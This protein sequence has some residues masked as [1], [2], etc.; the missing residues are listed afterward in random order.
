VPSNRFVAMALLAVIWGSSFVFIRVAV[1]ELDAGEVL[2]S[3]M[4][5]GALTLGPFASRASG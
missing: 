1:R 5:L 4:L 3:R 2:A